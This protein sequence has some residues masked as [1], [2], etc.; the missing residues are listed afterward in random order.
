M[1][2]K[3]PEQGGEVPAQLGMPHWRTGCA[4]LSQTK[5]SQLGG[6]G[7]GGWGMGSWGGGDAGSGELVCRGAAVT[8]S[9]ERAFSCQV[10]L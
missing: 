10:V 5:L 2:R 4:E 3:E 6:L 8:E 1:K 9:F 7:V